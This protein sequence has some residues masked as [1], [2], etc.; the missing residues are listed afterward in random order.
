MPGPEQLLTFY[1]PHENMCKLNIETI[2]IRLRSWARLHGSAL[3]VLKYS[4]V[5]DSEKLHQFPK[6]VC[7]VIDAEQL[8]IYSRNNFV[9]LQF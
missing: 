9:K 4:T 1:L 2:I 6:I 5:Y 7:H 3:L 8:P